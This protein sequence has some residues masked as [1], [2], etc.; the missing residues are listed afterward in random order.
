MLIVDVFGCQGDLGGVLEAASRAHV[1]R[2]PADW[3][4]CDLIPSFRHWE[5]GFRAVAVGF[6]G[7]FS[8]FVFWK[9]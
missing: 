5:M 7:G 1:G 3:E 8:D 9:L 6:S 2:N 4:I